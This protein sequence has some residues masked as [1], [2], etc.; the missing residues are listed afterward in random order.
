VRVDFYHLTA[1]PLEHVLPRIAERVLESGERL[2]LVSGDEALAAR[3]DSRLWT[4]EPVSFLPH[5]RV[6]QGGE[7][8]QPILIS[9]SVEPL[10][11]A[12]NVA[13][14]DGLWRD[15]VL[16]FARC[17]YFFD[18]ETIAGARTAWR[19]LAGRAGVE[20]HYWK[21]DEAGRWR[22]GP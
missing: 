14:G 11:G 22:E 9:P 13:L 1:H 3:L 7:A 17:F 6:G 16:D 12:V 8:D 20:P 5:G 4:Y 19:G 18:G 21:Q 2:L 15:A 10:N